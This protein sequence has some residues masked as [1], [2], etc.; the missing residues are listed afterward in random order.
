MQDQTFDRD[1]SEKM[2]QKLDPANLNRDYPPNAIR[3]NFT[4]MHRTVGGSAG[5]RPADLLDPDSCFLSQSRTLR[6]Y[7]GLMS[8][9][10]PIDL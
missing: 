9:P 3:Q 2:H 10:V 7:G 5:I 8:I 6:E 4:L 1:S